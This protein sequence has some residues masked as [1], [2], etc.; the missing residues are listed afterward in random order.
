MPRPILATIS[1]SN[2]A[3]NLRSVQQLIEQQV[4]SARYQ[5]CKT[6][7]IA[8]ANAYGHG[9]EAAVQGFAAADGI[10][11]IETE[12]L[13]RLRELGWHKE[14]VLLEGFFEEADLEI[15]QSAR[16]TTALHCQE[17]LDALSL[18]P[19]GAALKIMLKLNTGMNRLGFRPDR[20]PE[21][22]PRLA[23]LQAQTKV[24]EIVMMMHFADADSK[25]R[26]SLDYAWNNMKRAL[27]QLELKQFS[28]DGLS[29]C[30]SAA[31]L[32]YADELLPTAYKNYLRPGLCLYGASP[33]GNTENQEAIDFNLKPAMTLKAKI[34]GIQHVASGETVGY[35]SRFKA[36]ERTRVGVVACGYAD[37]YPRWADSST[38]VVVN[39]IE[40]YLVGRVSMDMI[41]INLNPVP[42]AQIGDWVT[43]WGEGGPT[44]ERVTECARMGSYETLCNLNQ[45][46]IKQII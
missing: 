14:L 22:L 42:D 20:L 29:V 16:A 12:M 28:V 43:L 8:K 25:D 26:S 40:T 7:A 33:M 24:G 11:V 30:N 6:I 46:V 35:G 31:A 4:G 23:Q 3:H 44:I 18:L 38:P 39:G 10:G 36:T 41:T 21:I 27:K 13:S 1:T 15:L 34:I 5:Q 17:Q 45:R 9:I 32:R 19:E 37:G 2:M